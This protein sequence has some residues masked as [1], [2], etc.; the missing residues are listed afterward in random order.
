MSER[1][2]A[3]KS[4]EQRQLSYFLKAYKEV[5]GQRLVSLDEYGERP[6]FICERPSSKQVGIELTRPHHDHDLVVWDRIWEPGCLMDS[7]DLSWAIY[8]AVANKRRK[9]KSGTWRLPRATILVVQLVDYTFDSLDWLK[10]TSLHHNY[11]STGFIE[12]W[13]PTGPGCYRLRPTLKKL[14]KPSCLR[15]ARA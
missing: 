3:Q 12:I 4:L 10:D 11:E 15:L 8:S 13:V 5:T 2:N 1:Q 7:D 14:G 6:N 9:L